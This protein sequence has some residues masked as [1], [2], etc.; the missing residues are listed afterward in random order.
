MTTDT[1]AI[2]GGTP[3]RARPMPPRRAL[4]EAES[5]MIAEALAHYRELD[6]DPGYQGVFER[7]YAEAFAAFM[8]GGHADAVA[9]GTAALFV[10]IAALELPPGSEVLVSPI[11]DPG[12]LSAIVL[13]R[14]VPRLV[15]SMPGSYNVGPEQVLARVTPAT[16]A[17]VLVHSIG[18]P[19]PI[20]AI[21]EALHARGVRVVED[22]SQA[23]G[24]R[25]AGRRVGAFGDIAAFSTMYRKAHITGGSG[26]VVY[27]RD[28][29][30]FRMALAHADR[31]KPRWVEGFD[32]RDPN[33]FLFPALNLHTD[34]LSSAI[35]L[36]S[37][38]RLDDTIARRL[39]FVAD[40][41]R[42]LEAEARACRPYG[43]GEGD[44][45][46]IYPIVVDPAAIGTDKT[47]FARA[48][49]AEGI[50][51]SPHYNYLAADWPWLRPWLSDGFD[52]P[53]ARAIRDRTFNLYLNENYGPE[54]AADA[55]A[56]ILK[57]ERHFAQPG[58]A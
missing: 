58:R 28:E 13:N 19:C 12:T 36:A 20:D 7:R 9:T 41:T 32:D 37:L 23:H 15:D 30:L 34:E 25:L 49:L 14:L 10:A 22:C 27:G 17:A 46:F 51:L 16:R 45:P 53:N 2:H 50:G 11:T 3:V 33:G 57:V 21:V 26:G 6:V 52:T 55:A 35:G 42:R 24:A 31:G 43:W 47:S 18:R 38:A 5:R 4:G 1:L 39:A 29:A 54:E 48:V 44:S 40:V 56:A 8:G